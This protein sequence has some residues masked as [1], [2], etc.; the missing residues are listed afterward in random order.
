MGCGTWDTDSFRSYS[1][2]KGLTTDKLGFVTSSVSNQEM[3]KARDLDP[4]LDPNSIVVCSN[5]GSQR[6]H[7]VMTPD[8]IRHVFHHFGFYGV[9]MQMTF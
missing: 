4:A 3:F 6:G 5:G 8:G 1:T 7:T 2:S 9:N